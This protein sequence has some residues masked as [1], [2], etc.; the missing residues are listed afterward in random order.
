MSQSR[1]IHLFRSGKFPGLL[2]LF[3][4]IFLLLL[5][6]VVVIM[7]VILIIIVVVIIIL[8]LILILII[9][10]CLRFESKK[11]VSQRVVKSLCHKVVLS[12]VLMPT[13]LSRF[14]FPTLLPG[15]A[16]DG[17]STSNTTDV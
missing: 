14:F 5:I 11:G 8:I 13:Y 10:S 15:L 7:V 16:G 17:C 2:I 9:S 4:L 12:Q 1:N 6:V 3:F